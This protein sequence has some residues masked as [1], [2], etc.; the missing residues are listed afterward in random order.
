MRNKIKQNWFRVSPPSFNSWRLFEII[1][2][3]I[4]NRRIKFIDR[5][6]CKSSVVYYETFRNFYDTQHGGMPDY[7][8]E[9]GDSVAWVL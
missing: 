1:S 2:R 6:F 7:K 3:F 9:G 8:W 5:F 4:I